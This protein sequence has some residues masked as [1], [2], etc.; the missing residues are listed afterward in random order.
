MQRS[1]GGALLWPYVLAGMAAAI[2]VVIFAVFVPG[3]DRGLTFYIAVSLVVG[4]ELLGCAQFAYSKLA[5]AGV[6]A[7]TPA[8]RQQVTVLVV[9]WFLLT[10]VV[11]LLAIDPKR[12]DKLAADRLLAIY[13][14]LT[15]LFFVGMYLMY[16]RDIQ[17]KQSEERLG[18]ER[19]AL[20]AN[21]TIVDDLLREVHEVGRRYPSCAAAADSTRRKLNV[22]R[23]ALQA[24]LVSERSLNRWDPDLSD[25]NLRLA[26]E[27]KGLAECSGELT[28]AAPDGIPALLQ[29]AGQRSEAVVRALKQREQ[30][31]IS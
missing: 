2:T 16:S 12:A 6:P 4:A 9:L 19:Q 3:P 20:V 30:R 24:S 5:Q 18:E 23:T 25:A 11:S 8:A 31:L 17:V 28:S 15:F 1:I 22:A 27:L 21:M 10:V 14:G 26:Q 7:A 29:Q 13:L